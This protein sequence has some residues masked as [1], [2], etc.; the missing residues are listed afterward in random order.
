MHI[1]IEIGFLITKNNFCCQNYEQTN[2]D[3]KYIYIKYI[4][5]CNEQL[6]Q[7]LISIKAEKELYTPRAMQKTQEKRT[8]IP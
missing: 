1:H 8:L 5:F 7:E 4:H 3:L 6:D 2:K